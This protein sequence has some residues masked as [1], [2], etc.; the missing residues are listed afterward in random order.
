[1]KPTG[2]QIGFDVAADKVR[3][4]GGLGMVGLGGVA[5]AG[6]SLVDKTAF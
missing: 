5:H 4:G 3:G 6:G 1:L 2:S